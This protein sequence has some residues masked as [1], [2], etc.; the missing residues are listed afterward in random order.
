ML[1]RQVLIAVLGLAVLIPGAVQAAPKRAE[2]KVVVVRVER[3]GELR[4]KATSE[5]LACV[6]ER[7][8]RVIS[9]DWHRPLKVGFFGAQ[10]VD[11]DECR[12]GL[13]RGI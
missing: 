10:S 11:R 1:R 6:R 8:L 4:V 2:T 3:Q 7:R 5:N 9:P 12:H 13:R